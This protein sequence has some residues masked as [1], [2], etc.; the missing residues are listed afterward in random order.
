MEDGGPS[1]HFLKR[2]LNWAPCF[3]RIDISATI[4]MEMI[5]SRSGLW[6]MSDLQA[7]ILWERSVLQGRSNNPSVLKFKG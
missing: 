5:S 4:S 1:S 6:S 3:E 7:K 2:N